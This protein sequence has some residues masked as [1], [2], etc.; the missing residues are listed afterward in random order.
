MTLPVSEELQALATWGG[1]R[2]FYNYPGTPC[3]RKRHI[4]YQVWHTDC[5]FDLCHLAVF[6][7]G[8]T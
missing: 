6:S 7:S 5:M 8:H 1:D 3:R 4:F 2:L